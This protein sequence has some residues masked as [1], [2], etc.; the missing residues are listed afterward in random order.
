M[1]KAAKTAV[2]AHFFSKSPQHIF[3]LRSFEKWPKFLISVCFAG[4][5]F[6]RVSPGIPF[7]R[8]WPG[9][10]ARLWRRLDPSRS[11]FPP[12]LHH[13]VSAH[14][15]PSPSS[16][17]LCIVFPLAFVTVFTHSFSPRLRHLLSAVEVKVYGFVLFGS[18]VSIVRS[19]VNVPVAASWGSS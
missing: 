11:L 18:I 17:C 9:K 19:M 2:Y 3:K 15:F 14:F 16:P 10:G 6:A 4:I 1:P 8:A 13:L 7:S 12:R 5:E